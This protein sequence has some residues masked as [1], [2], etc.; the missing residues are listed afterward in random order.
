MEKIKIIT[1]STCDLPIHMVNKLDIEVVPLSVNINS[2]SY[3]DGID[4]DFDGLDD[5]I[6]NTDDFPTTS[7]VSPD[8]FK[9]IYEKY[10]DKG[11]KIISIHVS[12]KISSTY[13][14]AFIARDILDTKDIF[15]YD[16]LNVSCGMGMLIYEAANMIKEGYS[17]SEVCAC[18]EDGIPKVKCCV[19][20]NSLSNLIRQGRVNKAIGTVGNI[21]RVKPII[22]MVDGEVILIDKIMGQKKLFDYLVRFINNSGVDENTLVWILHSKDD[23][24][25][26]VEKYLKS[27][28]YSCTSMH[29]GCVI[30]CYSGNK[31]I[32]IFFKKKYRR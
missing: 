2:K 22:S 11:Y 9:D 30:G 12:S 18:I 23:I 20:T 13:E 8:V 1:D 24:F 10:L 28:G 6:S 19:V 26:D 17:L 7:P 32:G 25:R 3:R 29:V 27:K 31:C 15:I 21:L 5:I 14:S 16:T 4:I